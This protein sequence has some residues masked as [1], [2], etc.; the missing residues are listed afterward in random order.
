MMYRVIFTT[1]FKKNVKAVAKRGYDMSLLSETIDI[2]REKG[3]LPK[4][5]KKHTL[6]G[7]YKGLFECHIKPDWLLV[8]KQEDDRLILQ[9]TNTGTH[10]DI[11]GK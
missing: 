1:E 10:S 7:N 9:F 3:D 2:L 4:K 8:W 11:F 6:T 5:Y